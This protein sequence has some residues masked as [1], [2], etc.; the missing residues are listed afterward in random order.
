MPTNELLAH[1]EYL[2]GEIKNLQA[3][4]Q[5]AR[6]ELATLKLCLESFEEHHEA[7]VEERLKEAEK[8]L[9]AGQEVSLC[10]PTCNCKACIVYRK[11]TD[12]LTPEPK[13]EEGE[14]E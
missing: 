11:I 1:N 12:F 7:Q 10:Q 3:E 14:G 5:A 13:G 6:E 2:Q 8:L 4:L 9:K